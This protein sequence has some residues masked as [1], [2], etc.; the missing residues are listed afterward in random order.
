MANF[1]T[2]CGKKLDKNEKCTCEKIKK[3]TK[4]F[5]NNSKTIMDNIKQFINYPID[6][7]NNLND[8]KENNYLFIALTSV[9]FGLI[10]TLLCHRFCFSKL[11]TISLLIFLCFI[12]FSYILN[13]TENLIYQKE[14]D[15]NNNLTIVATSSIILLVANV[16]AFLLSFLS[17]VLSYYLIIIGIILFI[18]Y[19]YNGLYLN[20]K[21]DKNKIGYLF[22]LSII[23]TLLIIKI[24]MRIF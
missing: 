22:V 14:S 21:V 15:Y 17:I 1:C 12:L 11:I 20:S 18:V 10:G 23:F 6:T 16:I 24:I 19:L 9:S 7:L 4:T 5:D 3:E 8:Y 13:V 2:K